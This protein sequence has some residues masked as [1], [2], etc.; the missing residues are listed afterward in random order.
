[1]VLK[2]SFTYKASYRIFTVLRIKLNCQTCIY[3]GDIN[4]YCMQQLYPGTS[5]RIAADVLST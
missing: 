5:T 1:M 4:T 2:T 3:E